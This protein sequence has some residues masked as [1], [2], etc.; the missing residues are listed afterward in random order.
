M[1]IGLWVH[2]EN[3]FSV[4]RR[5]PL[6]LSSVSSRTRPPESCEGPCRMRFSRPPEKDLPK[7]L[8]LRTHWRL[9]PSLFRP[10]YLLVIGSS[11]RLLK[12]D[13]Q[14]RGAPAF[15]RTCEE[16][17]GHLYFNGQSWI[18]FGLQ[19]TISRGPRQGTARS[20]KNRAPGALLRDQPGPL[21]GG[22]G[23]SLCAAGQQVLDYPFQGRVYGQ[24]YGARR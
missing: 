7:D 24:N 4:S 2:P 22:G 10:C 17:T 16:L 12:P 3:G 5:R 9:W 21:L 8:K 14:D 13:A 19:K 11:A 23:P 20:H 15:W 18:S 6:S 1:R